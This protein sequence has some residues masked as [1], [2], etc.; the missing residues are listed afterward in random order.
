MNTQLH[1]IKKTRT[2]RALVFLFFISLCSYF[3]V[4]CS[5]IPHIE[6]TVEKSDELPIKVELKIKDPSLM[7]NLFTPHDL[8][9]T[10]YTLNCPPISKDSTL[11]LWISETYDSLHNGGSLFTTNYSEF[12]NGKSLSFTSKVIV[13]SHS[14]R[15]HFYTQNIIADNIQ[16]IRNFFLT[17]IILFLLALFA[18]EVYKLLSDI[19]FSRTH[20]HQRIFGVKTAKAHFAFYLLLS[21]ITGV[22]LYTINIVPENTISTNNYIQKTNSL[23][24]LHDISCANHHLQVHINSKEDKTV[25]WQSEEIV[26]FIPNS[27]AHLSYKIGPNSLTFSNIA[28]GQDLDVRFYTRNLQSS[29]YQEIRLFVLTTLLLFFLERSFYYF[30]KWLRNKAFIKKN[31]K[32]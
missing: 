20:S 11:F 29:N 27:F 25:K 12:D 8:S 4:L 14:D 26:E 3:L 23:F 22:L 1:I 32:K 30:R 10:E 7:T 21:L 24:A 6:K 15:L 19:F 17:E 18:K 9:K 2:I 31:R 16:M 13:A 28:I 5:Q